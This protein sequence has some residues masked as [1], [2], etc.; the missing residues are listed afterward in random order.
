MDNN[1]TARAAVSYSIVDDL[2]QMLTAMSTLEV[3]KTFPTQRKSLLTSLGLVDPSD[4]KLIKFDTEKGEPCMPS[5][6]AFQ[7]LISI[8]NLVVYRCM[9]DEGEST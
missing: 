2:A 7:I 3:L 9:V 4:S 6:I 8:Q 5:T 1:A